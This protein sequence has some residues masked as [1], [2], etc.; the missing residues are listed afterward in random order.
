MNFVLEY[1]RLRG[2]EM[3]PS[4]EESTMHALPPFTNTLFRNF[5]KHR[6]TQACR[7]AL[8]KSN[9]V[10]QNRYKFL[11]RLPILHVSGG[12]QTLNDL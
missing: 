12:K 6:I 8:V 7:T 2:R 4:T 9:T 5:A 1:P 11:H 3:C 10:S